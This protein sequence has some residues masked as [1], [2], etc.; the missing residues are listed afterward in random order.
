MNKFN[1]SY[2]VDGIDVINAITNQDIIKF[3]DGSVNVTV[4]NEWFTGNLNPNKSSLVTVAAYL[5]SMDD[6]MVVAQIFD[7][8]NRKVPDIKCRLKITSPIYSRY[9]RVMLEGMNDAFGAKIF[10]NFLCAIG[11]S[12]IVLYDPH[13]EVLQHQLVNKYLPV[14]VMQQQNIFNATCGVVEYIHVYPDKGALKKQFQ[15]GFSSVIFDKTRD[16]ETGKILGIQCIEGKG[17]IHTEQDSP[18]IVVDDICEGG[19]TFLGLAK[20]FW[21]ISHP[22]NELELF[23]THGL[24]TNNAIV[25]LFTEG[26]Y[27]KINCFIMKESTYKEIPEEFLDRINVKHIVEGI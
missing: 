15:N 17:F 3:K 24:F 1:V 22:A 10:S 7:V 2:S 6:L 19:G 16:V 8:F 13:S 20:E 14:V 25:R 23:V 27:S 21:S 18:F 12:D 4:P 11:A 9:D 5:Q 26:L